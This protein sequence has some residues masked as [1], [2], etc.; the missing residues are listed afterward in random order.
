MRVL[1][2]GA[3]GFIGRHVLPLLGDQGIEL[4][5]LHRGKTIPGL[6][7]G[8]REIRGNRNQLAD[9]RAEL[10]RFAPDVILDF[11]L[12]TEQ[13][14]RALVDTF[15]GSGARVVAVS[16]A[17]VYRNYDGFRGKATAPPDPPP[18][19]EDAP[20][21]ET[22]YPYRDH[23]LPF[24]YAHD[25]EKI[26]IEQLVLG[27]QELP[28]TVLRLPAVYGPGDK[29]HR[30]KPY[31][32]RMSRDGGPIL[33]EQ[34][35]A[36]WRWTRGFVENVAAALALAVK[37]P[38]SVGHVYNVGDDPTLTEREWVTRIAALAGWRGEILAVPRAELPPDDRQPV[39]WRYH[40]W[41]D[42]TALCAELGYVRPVPLDEGLR[43][44]V[45]CECSVL[46]GA[47]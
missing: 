41:A 33:L 40:L 35:Q 28:A 9:C 36:S 13:Q 4:C 23:D 37:D 29:Q 19:S 47:D 43:R 12:Y 11:I 34:A 39:D 22:R 17:D 6:P 10:Q 18:L 16:S 15:R 24:A 3:T 38:R 21:R 7:E 14:A 2:I 8:V 5:V 46:D 45:E 30:L 20:L 27:V 32:E 42:T 26:L 44:A 25:Y 1:G 31:L